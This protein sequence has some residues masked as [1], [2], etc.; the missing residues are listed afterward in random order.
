MFVQQR[1]PRSLVAIDLEN[2]AGTS[3]PDAEDAQMVVSRLRGVINISARDHVVVAANP[4]N[5]FTDEIVRRD[6]H[7][8][9]RLRHG[10]NGADLALIE[11]IEVFLKQEMKQASR[12]VHQ[13]VICS[14]DGI[15]S[16]VAL[17]AH[18]VVGL[19]VVGIAVGD[20]LSHR[21]RGACN[22]IHELPNSLSFAL[23]S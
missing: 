10:R 17:W 12:T 16:S 23:A 9:S 15:F 21:L 7:G 22:E 6:L 4:R 13:L 8:S 20:Q 3:R 19:K 1:S 14:G 5:A 18:H 2:L 11:E